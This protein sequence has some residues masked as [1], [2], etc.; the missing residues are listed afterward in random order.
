MDRAILKDLLKEIGIDIGDVVLE[1]ASHT[2]HTQSKVD[3]EEKKGAKEEAAVGA[4]NEARASVASGVGGSVGAADHAPEGY[5]KLKRHLGYVC[6]CVDVCICVC[7]CLC[8]CICV[9]ICVYVL[10]VWVFMG[11]CK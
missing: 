5:V 6:V 7:G 3:L 8:A 4:G 11:K 9:C 2:S 1:P 10:V